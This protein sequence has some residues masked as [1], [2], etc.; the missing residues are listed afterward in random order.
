MNSEELEIRAKEIFLDIIEFEGQE[1]ADKLSEKAS[2]S[3]A[4][5]RRVNEL[6]DG[7]DRAERDA[8]MESKQAQKQ[9]SRSIPKR[10]GPFA[11][12]RKIAAGGM[13]TVY[14]AID[15]E[16]NR[17]VALKVPHNTGPQREIMHQRLRREG[18][19][20]AQLDH[21]HIVKIYQAGFLD[22][23]VPYIAMEFIDGLN[24]SEMKE[25]ARITSTDIIKWGQQLGQALDYLHRANV[26]HRDVKPK[27]IL[28]NENGDAVLTDFGIAHMAELT[29]I[30]MGRPGTALY[31]CPEQV[32]DTEIDGRCDIFSLG[33]VLYEL[34]TGRYPHNVDR[35]LL[36][37]GPR[38]TPELVRAVSKCLETSAEERFQTGQE[39][40]EALVKKDFP[41]RTA[42]T[43]AGVTMGVLTIVTAGWFFVQSELFSSL[44]RS[45]PLP[46][47]SATD[48]LGSIPE[49]PAV[50]TPEEPA[51]SYPEIIQSLQEQSLSFNNLMQELNELRD[52]GE[53]VFGRKSDV[54]RP[55]DCYVFVFDSQQ[56]PLQ[57]LFGPGVDTRTDLLTNTAIEDPATIYDNQPAIWVALTP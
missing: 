20:I 31:M 1:R 12:R 6:L 27:N 10:I 13:G 16:L 50:L 44:T 53:L 36:K 46:A 35:D 41:W 24:L 47:S 3:E 51:L 37:K 43:Y 45:L 9:Q 56:E 17:R 54:L 19:A 52:R 28:I 11:V 4:L 34:I 23:E 49:N 14:E 21:P 29:R 38:T 2:G 39:L 26:L 22:G 33:L 40:A 32:E 30:T 7:F 48:P 8:F 15:T 25:K 18:A 5:E 57:Y 55:E 42:T